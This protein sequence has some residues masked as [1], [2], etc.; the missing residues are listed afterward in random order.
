[1]ELEQIKIKS[2]EVLRSIT[3]TVGVKALSFQPKILLLCLN[4]HPSLERNVEMMLKVR[5]IIPSSFGPTYPSRVYEENISS[6]IM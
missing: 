2:T 5:F 6:V 1:M 3:S 4:M